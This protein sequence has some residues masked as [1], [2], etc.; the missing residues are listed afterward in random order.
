MGSNLNTFL[1]TLLGSKAPITN[2][3]FSSA[4]IVAMSALIAKASSFGRSYVNYDDYVALGAEL[5]VSK[6]PQPNV[7]ES[8]YQVQTTLG[9][10]RF[11]ETASGSHRVTDTYNFNPIYG[12]TRADSQLVF[13]A[14]IADMLGFKPG[15]SGYRMITGTDDPSFTFR[16]SGIRATAYNAARAY[17]EAYGPRE[18]EGQGRAVEV[19]V[20]PFREY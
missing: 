6:K 5:E 2:N 16:R 11:E 7:Y 20:R 13:N 12:E 17:G 3:N 19:F 9:Q 1:G 10:F 18:D 8:L 4:D 15:S 14:S